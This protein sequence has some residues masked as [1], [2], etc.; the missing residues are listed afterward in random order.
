MRKIALNELDALVEEIL[1]LLPTNKSTASLIA[2]S[3]H[4][5]AGKTTFVQALGHQL[6]IT[7]TI[8]SPTYV[9]M[10]SYP[11]SYKQY[12]T[13]VHID[14]YRLVEP[15]EFT[16]LKPDVFLSN[17]KNLVCIEWPEQVRGV[18]PP[19]DLTITF[20]ADPPP[21]QEGGANEGERYIEVI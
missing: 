4:L 14:A 11:I 1:A 9:L 10:K 5:G 18:L 15:A 7:E 2:L 6:G 12:S 17:P 8:Q 21:G 3:G 16:T 19:P 20:S 13:F